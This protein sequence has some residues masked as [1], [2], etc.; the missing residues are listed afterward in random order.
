MKRIQAYLQEALQD[1]VEVISATDLKANLGEC[2]DQS[3]YGKSF[4]VKRK[5]KIVAFIVS[6][7]QGN[8]LH[9]ILPNEFAELLD[10]PA[11][12]ATPPVRRMEAENEE[13]G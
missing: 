2:L 1:E 7:A 12:A 6:P 3:F 11:S 4:C 9:Q 8:G 10:S 5:G 13:S